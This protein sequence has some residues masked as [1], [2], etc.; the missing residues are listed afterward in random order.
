MKIVIERVPRSS[1]ADLALTVEEHYGKKYYSLD[2]ILEQTKKKPHIFM[3]QHP[4][5]INCGIIFG[6]RLDCEHII[7]SVFVDKDGLISL[8]KEQIKEEFV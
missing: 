4:I 6:H 8:T 3:E 5:K 1:G 7:R 2:D